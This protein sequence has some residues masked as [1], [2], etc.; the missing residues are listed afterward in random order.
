MSARQLTAAQTCPRLLDVAAQ[1]L[2]DQGM[3]GLTLDAVAK[4]AGVGKGG[5]LHHFPS[6]DALVE[7]VLRRLSGVA[8]ALNAAVALIT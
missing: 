5:L 3:A 1:T 8:L 2:R 4:E 7:A 6:K